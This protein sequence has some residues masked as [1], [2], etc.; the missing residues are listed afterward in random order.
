MRT[1]KKRSCG[2]GALRDEA[3]RDDSLKDML[4]SIKSYAEQ[5]DYKYELQ[6]KTSAMVREEA[7]QYYTLPK[8]GGYTLDDYYALPDEQR[9]ELIDGVFYDLAAPRGLHQAIAGFLY[10]KFMDFIL[11]NDGP[12]YPFISPVDVQ[13]DMDNKTMVEPDVMILCDRSKLRDTHIYGAPDLVV[14]VLSPST[15]KKDMQLKL[16]KYANAG[17]REYWMIDP[18]KKSVIQYDLEN[19]E[20]PF[21]CGFDGVVPVRIWDGNCK[22]DFREVTEAVSRF[23]DF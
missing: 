4:D 10:K 7:A 11:E 14:E 18:K 2:E 19:M 16:Y 15:R 6:E 12:C 23:I 22:I 3:L 21:V 9:V 1:D 8:G 17:V 5:D 20:V 13:L